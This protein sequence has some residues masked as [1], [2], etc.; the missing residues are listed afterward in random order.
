M[1]AEIEE[2]YNGDMRIDNFKEALLEVI[3]DRC[4]KQKIPVV[5]VI[6]LLE[7]IKAELVGEIRATDTNL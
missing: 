3:Y 6:G 5:A 7:L 4:E 2:L 1:Q